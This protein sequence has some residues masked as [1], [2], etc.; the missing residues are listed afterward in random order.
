MEAPFYTN[1]DKPLPHFDESAIETSSNISNS[2][3]LDTSKQM[4]TGS[5]MPGSSGKHLDILNSF[6]N[7]GTTN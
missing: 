1:Q 2:N 6:L 5:T 7:D 4:A 3:L